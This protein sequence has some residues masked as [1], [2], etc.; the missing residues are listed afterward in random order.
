M[1]MTVLRGFGFVLA[2]VLGLGVA[3]GGAAAQSAAFVCRLDDGKTVPILSNRSLKNVAVARINVRDGRTIVF[4]PTYLKLFQ[5]PTR[6]FWLAHECAHQQLGQV[7][8][9]YQPK[10]EA[11]A[12]CFGIQHLLLDKRLT[13][14]ELP[15]VLQ[16]ISKLGSSSPL[17]PKGP[18][19]AAH[20]LECAKRA[21][22]TGK[23]DVKVY[24]EY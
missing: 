3:V 2:L 17:Y 8:N 18:A 5:V 11:E 15:A 7:G 9:H 13:A 1:E 20:I 4:N 19:R 10:T 23:L 21:L 14:D 24:D 12:D 6:W 22:K 16:D